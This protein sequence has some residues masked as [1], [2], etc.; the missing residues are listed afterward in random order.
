MEEQKNL[1]REEEPARFWGKWSSELKRI[2]DSTSDET[3]LDIFISDIT[4][5]AE[6]KANE[7]R[8]V[9]DLKISVEEAFNDLITSVDEKY[10]LFL[11]LQD[12][13]ESDASSVQLN[14]ATKAIL[15]SFHFATVCS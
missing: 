6:R 3:E 8:A 9:P 2:S 11:G 13:L 14:D 15:I 4:E 12:L 7:Y 10:L 1:G 5:L